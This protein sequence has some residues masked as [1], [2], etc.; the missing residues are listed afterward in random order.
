MKQN[1]TSK[2]QLSKP[3]SG[4]TEIFESDEGAAG[5]IAAMIGG[6]YAAVAGIAFRGLEDFSDRR[7]EARVAR[8]K[9]RGGLTGAQ[10]RRELAKRVART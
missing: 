7:A 1:S 9:A 3:E 10:V 2:A 8:K 4:R 5:G 6:I